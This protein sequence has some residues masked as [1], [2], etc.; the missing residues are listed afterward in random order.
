MKNYNAFSEN[1]GKE[2][3]SRTKGF[4]SFMKQLL[5][6][7]GDQG[8]EKILEPLF[9]DLEEKMKYLR[10]EKEILEKIIQNGKWGKVESR[11]APLKRALYGLEHHLSMSSEE[12]RSKFFKKNKEEIQKIKEM[13]QSLY[14]GS[15]QKNL[16]ALQ[17]DIT[18][19]QEKLTSL[20]KQIEA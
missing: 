17:E 18:D 6:K 3:P 8:K 12:T 11:I 20:E 5:L 4:E 15:S 13:L 2:T 10:Q 9:V 14:V 7:L 16:K 19:V 1:Y